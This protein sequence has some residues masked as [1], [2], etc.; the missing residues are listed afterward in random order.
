MVDLFGWRNGRSR[1]WW[2]GTR[3]YV[4]LKCVGKWDAYYLYYSSPVVD[5]PL[6]YNN[7]MDTILSSIE[8]KQS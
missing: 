6:H 8:S 2:A 3:E 1:R 4:V 7:G 5:T